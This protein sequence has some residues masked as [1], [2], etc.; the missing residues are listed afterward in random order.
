M[1]KYYPVLRVSPAEMNAYETLK[2]STKNQIIPILEAKRISRT[3]C[4]ATW[5]NTNNTPG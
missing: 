1:E 4:K 3:A 5:W 2:E